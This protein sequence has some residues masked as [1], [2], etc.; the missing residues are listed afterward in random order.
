M[1]AVLSAEEQDQILQTI[2]M[3]EVITMTQPDDYQSIEIL[4]EAYLKL[5]RTEDALSTSIRLAKAYAVTG[6]ISLAFQECEGILSTTPDDAEIQ[7]L[8]TELEAQ[9]QQAVQHSSEQSAAAL[10]AFRREEEA[11]DVGRMVVTEQTRREDLDDLE[12]RLQEDDGNEGLAKFLIKHD[13]A[14]KDIVME[15][16]TLVRAA[17]AKRLNADGGAYF[18]MTSL[19]EII[20]KQGGIPQ[21]ELLSRLIDKTRMAYA[22]VDSYQVDRHIVQLLP[23]TLTLGRLIMPFDKLSR[24]VFVATCNPLDEPGREAVQQALEFSIH[25]FIA[26]PLAIYRSLASIY[27]LNARD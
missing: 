19:L 8:M 21:D 5:G 13:I 23:E 12:W 10:D 17:N 20:S 24:T 14:P 7:A 1:S 27:R 18:I 26:S 9:M 15:S 6:Q 3:F 2:D 25:W 11:G 4:K 16:M 22:P